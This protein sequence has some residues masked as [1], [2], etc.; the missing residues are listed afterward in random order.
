MN[1]W[2]VFTNSDAFVPGAPLLLKA[3]G[4][5]AKSPDSGDQLVIEYSKISGAIGSVARAG[6]GWAIFCVGD[7]NWRVARE[8][9]EYWIVEERA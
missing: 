2:T 8:S 3:K 9:G 1:S 6:A 4:H 7:E 5:N